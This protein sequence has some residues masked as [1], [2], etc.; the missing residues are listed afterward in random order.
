MFSDLR[1]SVVNHDSRGTRLFGK[2]E[3]LGLPRAL[4][5]H[6][7]VGEL[8]EVARAFA[9]FVAHVADEHAETGLEGGDFAGLRGVEKRVGH[10]IDHL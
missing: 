3:R 5:L 4:V 2:L 1:E 9:V 6:A 10:V 8:A 7:D